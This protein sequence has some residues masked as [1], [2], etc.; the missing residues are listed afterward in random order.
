MCNVT[1]FTLPLWS[2][3]GVTDHKDKDKGKDKDKD[4]VDKVDMAKLLDTY[5]VYKENEGIVAEN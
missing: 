4:K 3:P 5:S 2:C 1:R